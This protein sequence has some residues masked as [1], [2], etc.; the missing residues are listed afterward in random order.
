MHRGSIYAS[1]DELVSEA[2]PVP[3]V[4]NRITVFK[5][6]GMALEDLVAADLAYR[7]AKELGIGTN[8]EA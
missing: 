4:D 2:K 3:D 5:S 1:I 8:V 6:V 7:R